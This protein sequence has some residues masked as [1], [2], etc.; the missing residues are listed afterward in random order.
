MGKQ[1]KRT[2]RREEG[3]DKPAWAAD[4]ITMPVKPQKPV[5]KETD[6]FLEERLGTSLLNQLAQLKAKVVEEA[7][8]ATVKAQAVV[9]K[10]KK[11]VAQ[12]KSAKDR[13]AEDPDASFAELFDPQDS[14]EE[15]AFAELLDESKLDWHHFKE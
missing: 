14:D 4:V 13:L 7:E 11:K 2:G 12:G 8:A 3:M 1:K 10:S 15:E 9:I 5:V 6:I